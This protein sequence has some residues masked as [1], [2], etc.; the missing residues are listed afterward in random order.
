M[1]WNSN[2]CQNWPNASQTVQDDKTLR[3]DLGFDDWIRDISNFEEGESDT[4]KHLKIL[5][6]TREKMIPLWHGWHQRDLTMVLLQ[7]LFYTA[8]QASDKQPKSLNSVRI[9]YE[10]AINHYRRSFLNLRDDPTKEVAPTTIVLLVGSPLQPSELEAIK[11][12]QGT[13]KG[14]TADI[15]KHN[16]QKRLLLGGKKRL[17]TEERELTTIEGIGSRGST[18][19]VQLSPSAG[20]QV[21][22]TR[23][24]QN[25]QPV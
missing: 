2:K 14:L 11:L 9:T 3:V 22:T 25:L 7:Q 17:S 13:G 24:H 19:V 20:R 1:P 6:R 10:R 16:Q 15:V 8:L 23:A 4:E 5:N 21:R 18:Q 12:C